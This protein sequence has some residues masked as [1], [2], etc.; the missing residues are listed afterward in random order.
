[1][2]ICFECDAKTKSLLD[3]FLDQDYESYGEVI[4]VALSNLSVLHTGIEQ[5]TTR[6]L[7]VSP[8]SAARSPLKI[9]A[10]AME[11]S[12]TVRAGVPELL[13]RGQSLADWT[14]PLTEIA[15]AKIGPNRQEKNGSPTVDQ[16]IFGQFSKLLPAKVSCRAI[17]NL[18]LETAGPLK[19]ASVATRVAAEASVLTKYLQELDKARSLSRDDSLA[20]GFPSNEQNADRSRLRYAN[21]FVGSLTTQGR[22]WG[23]LFDL[24]LAEIHDD[25]APTIELSKA[26]WTF[27]AIANPAL[28][29]DANPRR[30]S[31]EEIAF[32]LEHIKANIPVEAFAFRT[33]LQAIRDG[34]D[35]PEKLDQACH[36]HLPVSRKDLS[37]AFVTSQRTGVISRLKELELVNRIR[38]GVRVSY[39]VT[40]NG[41]QFLNASTQKPQPSV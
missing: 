28:D 15:S 31:D 4:S 33:I 3:Q 20:L 9:Q 10:M 27:A 32:L 5:G 35:T 7:V 37:D 36:R 18:S 29:P 34:E 21:Q 30:F 17:A 2:V 24:Q 12:P 38:N 16:W 40:K 14:P 26:G 8:D 6:A 25:E 23:L 41:E 22:P 11:P 19:L 39:S 13:R 1:M